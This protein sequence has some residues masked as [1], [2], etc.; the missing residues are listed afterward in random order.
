[1]S[2]PARKQRLR[3]DLKAAMQARATAPGAPLD[4]A[5]LHGRPH[6]PVHRRPRR[7]A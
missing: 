5:Q 1:M 6:D 2:A 3:A 4:D 7:C